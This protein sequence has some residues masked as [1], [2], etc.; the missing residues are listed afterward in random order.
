MAER[1]SLYIYTHRIFLSI[2]Q[3]TLRCFHILAI[4][5][6]AANNVGEVVQTS[7]Q[8]SDLISFGYDDNNVD[9]DDDVGDDNSISLLDFLKVSQ[10]SLESTLK[11]TDGE[12]KATSFDSENSSLDPL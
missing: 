11:T 2:H 12:E 4:V 1:Y 5:N 6:N 9:D 8:D 3:W 7:L 10:T